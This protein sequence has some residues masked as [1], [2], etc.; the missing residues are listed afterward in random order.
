MLPTFKWFTLF[1]H[2]SPLAFPLCTPHSL[3]LFCKC[4]CLHMFCPSSPL[5]ATLHE[6]GVVTVSSTV[7][8]QCLER[9]S[10]P[11]ICAEWMWWETLK[12]TCNPV[13]ECK[14]R[15]N[16]HVLLENPEQSCLMV[17]KGN[18]KKMTQ[19]YCLGVSGMLLESQEEQSQR[20]LVT[21]WGVWVLFSVHWN[22]LTS[23]SSGGT[24][25]GCLKFI[26][27]AVQ[28][29]VEG[30]RLD[31]RFLSCPG[32]RSHCWW[33]RQVDRLKIDVGIDYRN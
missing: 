9:R 13:R 25:P 4:I 28:R 22:L 16:A 14:T 11:Q 15:Q 32:E 5:H 23:L 19:G 10:A 12:V 21:V 31:M 33:R 6:V 18:W 3:H 26:L 1:S 8:A 24:R 20:T 30:A 17:F 27:D 29:A 7:A 2:E